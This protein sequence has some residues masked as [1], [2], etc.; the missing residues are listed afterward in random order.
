[1]SNDIKTAY[2]IGMGIGFICGIVFSVL[3]FSIQ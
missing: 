3:L 2:W 1:M